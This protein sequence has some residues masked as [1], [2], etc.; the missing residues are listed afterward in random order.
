[1]VLIGWKLKRIPRKPLGWLNRHFAVVI[2]HE[3][4]LYD[5]VYIFLVDHLYDGK[6]IAVVLCYGT[7]V[8]VARLQIVWF[9][10]DNLSYEIWTFFYLYFIQF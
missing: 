3:C 10:C 7:I 6:Q 2:I 8:V 9:L 1:M 5:N 4:S